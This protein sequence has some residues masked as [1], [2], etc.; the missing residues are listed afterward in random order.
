MNYL[1][2][3]DG[4]LTIKDAEQH[5]KMIEEYLKDEKRQYDDEDIAY[6]KGEIADAIDFIKE[7]KAIQSLAKNAKTPGSDAAT[8]A[9]PP[10]PV[11]A[12]A[13]PQAAPRS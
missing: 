3:F 11:S 9:P 5:I 1:F 8:F 6:L 7:Q 2:D 13:Q 12:P 10:T 4:Y